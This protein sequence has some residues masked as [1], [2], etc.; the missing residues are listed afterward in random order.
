MLMKSIE[1]IAQCAAQEVSCP[2]SSIESL[3]DSEEEQD[4]GQD[5]IQVSMENLDTEDDTAEPDR[6]SMEDREL[7]HPLSSNIKYNGRRTPPY[8]SPGLTRRVSLN[9]R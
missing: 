7:R 2:G 9:K 8:L 6:S 5:T 3:Q 4:F 1:Q